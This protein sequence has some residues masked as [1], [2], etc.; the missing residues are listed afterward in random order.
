MKGREGMTDELGPVMRMKTSRLSPPVG[1]NKMSGWMGAEGR[2]D[3]FRS[4]RRREPG[5]RCGRRRDHCENLEST[6]D[7]SSYSHGLH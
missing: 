3:K 4:G 7:P 1:R 5:R 6:R 2:P